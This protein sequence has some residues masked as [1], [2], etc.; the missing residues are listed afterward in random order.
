MRVYATSEV[1]KSL[2]V[3]KM[4]LLRYLSNGRLPPPKLF[5]MSHG[6]KVWLW[7]ENE[8]LETL[9]LRPKR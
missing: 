6:R 7:T 2:Q 8:F 5:M 3:C 1:A 4:T 9:R